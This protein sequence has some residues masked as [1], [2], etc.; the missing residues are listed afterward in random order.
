MELT[1]SEELSKLKVWLRGCTKHS[2]VV[3]NADDLNVAG[4]ASKTKGRVIFFSTKLQNRTICKH[5][6]L[7]GTAVVTDRG[8]ILICTGAGSVAVCHISKIP[9]TWGGKAA[10]NIQNV[11]AAV[12]GCWSLGYKAAQIKRALCGYG[13]NSSDNKGRLEYYE[14]GEIK[15]ILDYGHNPAGIKE[16]VRTL[17][18]IKHRKMIGCIGLPGDRGDTTVRNLA[19]EAAKGFDLLYI[20]EDADL[21]GRKSGEIAGIIY[22]EAFVENGK[23]TR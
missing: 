11:L 16:I 10:H 22:D 21:R 15:V 13:E 8:R 7:G 2:Y 14:I 20:K 17:K 5:L 23:E 18:K 9:L 19:K 1:T 12:A 6:A 3:L 4:I